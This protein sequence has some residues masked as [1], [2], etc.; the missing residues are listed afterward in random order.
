MEEKIKLHDKVFKPYIRHDRIIAAVDDVAEK[1]NRDFY[2]CNDVPVILCVLNGS[3]PFTGELLQRITFPCQVISIKM[4][5]YQGTQSTG[6]VLNVMGL[7]S[8]VKGRRVIICEDIVDTGNTIVALKEMLLDK[9]GAADVRICTLL[10][11]PDVYDKPD[12]LDYVGMEIPNAFIVGFGLDYDEL[13]RNNKD[14]YVIDDNPMKKY[15]ILFG[16]PGA[17]KGT[18]A[19]AIAQ[20][21]N[22]K[23]ISTGELLRAEIAAGTELGKQAKSLIDAGMLVPD[24]V[25]EGMI[26]TAFD[27]VKGVDGFL[28]DGFPRNLA[29]AADLDKILEKRGESVTAVV[30]LMIDDDMIFQRIRGRAIIEGRADD[31]SDETIA[32]RIKTYHSQTEPLIDYYKKA[33]KYHEVVVNG[34]TIEENR[35]RVLAKMDSIA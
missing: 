22:L 20:K 15:Y 32:N 25:V 28:L 16:P 7:T 19:G 34:G 26:E 31:A 14:I 23:H 2:H 4:S 27:T 13:G 1:L 17:G 18:H 8:S 3:I 35:A 21:Y 29:Q 6:T 24:S 30:G 11:K 33:D 9:E 5:S 10:V 12:K